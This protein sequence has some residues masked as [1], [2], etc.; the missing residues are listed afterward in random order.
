LLQDAKKEIDLLMGL[1]F[2][3]NNNSWLTFHDVQGMAESW[4]E[5][6]DE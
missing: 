3:K 2:F 1:N 6:G 5:R 4:V